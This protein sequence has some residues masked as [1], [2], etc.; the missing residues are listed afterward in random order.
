MPER[1]CFRTPL[2][3]QRLHGSPTLLKP[4]LQHFYPNFPLIYD[5]F[6][7][8][9]SLLLESK[10]LG[11]FGNTLTADNMYSRQRWEKFWQQVQTVLS[12]KGKTF[13]ENF[14]AFWQSTRTFWHFKKKLTFVALIFQKLLTLRNVVTS[15]P[16][17]FCFRTPLKSQRVHGS[18]TLQKAA[19]E[20]F[21]SN[22]PLIQENW[23]GKH[24]P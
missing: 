22:F 14:I 19:L 10:I 6:S 1:L 21:Y 4:A 7:W 5:K 2:K 8:K 24:L 18:Q 20:H 3:S 17:S 9:T 23:V 13:S 15:M 11:L 12:Q 16:E